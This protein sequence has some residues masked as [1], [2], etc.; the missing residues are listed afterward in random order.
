[1]NKCF[2]G[3]KYPDKWLD[4]KGARNGATVQY[5]R[6]EVCNKIKWATLFSFY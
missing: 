4:G 5:K 2:W 1:M 3:H 6:C